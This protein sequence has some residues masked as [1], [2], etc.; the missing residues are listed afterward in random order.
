[1]MMIKIMII[2]TKQIFVQR[3]AEPITI[4]RKNHHQF[5]Q[6][7]YQK[8]NPKKSQRIPGLK[9]QANPVP[10][11]PGFLQ[12]PVPKIPGLKLLIPLGPVAHTLCLIKIPT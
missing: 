1:M 12:N 7:W 6:Q 5:D 11:I 9:F 3:L 4:K 2:M 8:A 10:K